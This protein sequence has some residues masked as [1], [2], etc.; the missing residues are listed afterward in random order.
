MSGYTDEVLGQVLDPNVH[1]IH[2]P[3]LQEVLLRQLREIL[4]SD[5]QPRGP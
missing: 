5:P 3:F 2:K 1:F 4:A